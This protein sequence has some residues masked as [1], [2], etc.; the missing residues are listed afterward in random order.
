[1]LA[2]LDPDIGSSSVEYVADWSRGDPALLRAAA[3]T[4][5]RVAAAVLTE[6]EQADQQNIEA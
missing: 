1:V 5:H 2:A 4:V 3:E 6:L